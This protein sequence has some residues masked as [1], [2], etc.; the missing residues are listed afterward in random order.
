MRKMLSSGKVLVQQP[1][2]RAADSRSWPNGFSTTRRALSAQPDLRQRLRHRREQARR[3]RQIVQRPL[4][5]AELLAQLDEGRRV[6]VVAVDIAQ[7]LHQPLQRRRVGA[8]VM[9]QAVRRARL[10]L[11]QGP[12][13]LGDADD[14]DVQPL[15]A[16][17]PQQRRE[18]SACRRDRRSRRRR[19]LRPTAGRPSTS[20]SFRLLDMAAELEAHR[21]QQRSAYSA[22]PREFEA[23]KQRRADHRRRHAFV[24]RRLQRPAALAGIRDAALE[25]RQLRVLPQRAGGEVEQ[26]GADHAAAPPDLGDLR[27]VD[28]VLDSDRD[29]AA[30]SSRRPPR[31]ASGR[32]WRS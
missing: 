7:Q 17:Q 14:R 16:H 6:V 9:L 11:I 21:R 22:L 31:A 27:D 32:H 18:R 3:H 24:D 20:P 26:P 28:I 4:R 10:Q 2:Q 23:R 30:A 8:A 12:A 13:G 29:R 15:V 19:R 1:V 5:L 25:I